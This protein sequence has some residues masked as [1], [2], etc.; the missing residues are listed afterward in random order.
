MTIVMNGNIMLGIE[1]I[2][3]LELHRSA[4]KVRNEYRSEHDPL[5]S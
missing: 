4:I 3:A 5:G 2:D 1:A